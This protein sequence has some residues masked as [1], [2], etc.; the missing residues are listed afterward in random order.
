MA[1]F[2]IYVD[3]NGAIKVDQLE[4][5]VDKL[6]DTQKRTSKT[7]DRL[8]KSTKN[9]SKTFDVM[10]TAVAGV[11]A[12]MLARTVI[13]YAD[14]WTGVESRLK[15]VTKSTSE[16]ESTQAALFSVA[17]RS[18]QSYEST[19][20]LYTRMARATKDL[21]IPQ[22]QLLRTTETINKALIVSGAST[23]ESTST[24]IQLSQAL[25]SGVLRGEEFNSIS[26]NGSEVLNMLGE[27]L[28]KTTGELREMAKEGQLTTSV[29]LKGLADGAES[30]DEKFK[31]MNLTVSQATLSFSNNMG[32]L[33]DRA[34]NG[35][36]VMS[37]LAKSIKWVGEAAV[38]ADEFYFGMSLEDMEYKARIQNED[39]YYHI[40]KRNAGLI[41]DEVIPTQKLSTA[42]MKKL[43][44]ETAL[45][46][47][48]AYDTTKFM[49]QAELEL[50][51]AAKKANDALN[52]E[53]KTIQDLEA[54]DIER[55]NSQAQMIEGINLESQALS[56]NSKQKEL[57][58]QTTDI[59]TESTNQLAVATSWLYDLQGNL[60]D[61]ESRHGADSFFTEGYEYT[62]QVGEA[63]AT[64][65]VAI[66]SF[67]NSITD[68]SSTT[69]NATDALDDFITVFEDE[70]MDSIQNNI[71]SL[72][73]ISSIS[74]QNTLS[75]SEALLAVQ[76]VHKDLIANPLDVEI[77][78]QFVDAYNT[79]IDSSSEYL[80]DTTKFQTS[81]QLAFAKATV[82]TQTKELGTTAGQTVSVLDSM[83]FLLESIN[84]V[85]A[86][87]FLTADEK[88]KITS[89][90]NDVNTNNDVLLGSSGSLVGS[91]RIIN[92]SINSASY[93]DNTGLATDS[94]LKLGIKTTETTPL[95]GL[96]KDSTFTDK[97]LTNTEL[98][99]QGLYKGTN[100]NA[101]VN[102]ISGYATDANI[103][104]QTYY[105]NTLLAKDATVDALELTAGSVS[106]DTTHLAKSTDLIGTN[107]V[108]AAIDLLMGSNNS[109]IEI[110]SIDAAAG[111]IKA[112]T[113]LDTSIGSVA[114]TNSSIASYTS[115]NL[116]QYNTKGKLKRATTTETTVY[117][118]VYDARYDDYIDI[119]DGTRAV[120]TYEYYAKGGFTG[121]G[122]GQRDATGFRQAGV[123]HEGEWVAPQWMVNNNPGLFNNL[124]SA[125]QGRGSSGGSNNQMALGMGRM[126][127]KMDRLLSLVRQVT[128]GGDAMRTEL[129]G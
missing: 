38:I 36:G 67:N 44:E 46:L 73:S 86:D 40:M 20:T 53:L 129:V 45:Y 108:S 77:G 106:V 126:A 128:N 34:A 13:N 6:G 72:S 89:I 75:Y 83:N 12:V 69:Y 30:V 99:N 18:R 74:N 33:I 68:F 2:D 95:T 101:N 70:F 23:Q 112:D 57:N 79:F 122:M 124:E 21:N 115:G 105:D 8:A 5:K 78:E 85:M 63:A 28:G 127:D 49:T 17:E 84:L 91:N 88:L 92:E 123:V 58:A 109:G 48:V 9:T 24:I 35:T 29:V 26:E 52:L 80:S 56:D 32:L 42:E 11:S 116:D 100:I 43:R 50:A 4:R 93:Y 65:N 113:G 98:T 61:A 107:S 76:A 47:N 55:Y 97:G 51:T 121:G 3:V 31:S 22:E 125:R 120:S 114:S 14:A 90:A 41:K 25:A 7:S 60:I 118:S 119:E 62:V 87:G 81:E 16:L 66:N 27:S 59:L 117:K 64:S 82:G 110:K 94:T 10:K 104:A 19:A 71:D 102:T 96:M 103:S 39:D 1:Q 15:L 54:A 37:N 111:S